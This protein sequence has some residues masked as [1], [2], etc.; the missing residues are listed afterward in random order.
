[1][2]CTFCGK[3]LQPWMSACP[4]CG[5]A[6]SDM[7][8]TPF[9]SAPSSTAAPIN[10]MFPD[11][12]ASSQ[13][14]PFDSPSFGPDAKKHSTDYGI[15]AI[16]PATSPT[17]QPSYTPPPM[18]AYTTPYTAQPGQAPAAPPQMA[19]G[20][21]T[22]RLLLLYV[23][24]A[25]IALASGLGLILYSAVIHP[26]QL[27][28]QATATALAQANAAAS[29]TAQANAAASATAQANANAT[30]TAAAQATADAQATATALQNIY[31][32]ATSGA[33]ALNDS[34]AYNA[35]GWDVGLAQGGGGCSFYGGAYHVAL[36]AKGYYFPCTANA[37]NFGNFAFQ[38][39]VTLDKGDEAGILFRGNSGSAQGYLFSIR[40][41]GSYDLFMS[42]NNNTNKDLAYGFSPV[43]KTGLNQTNVLTVVA[44]A[45]NMYL[46]INKQFAASASDLTYA[47]GQIGVFVADNATPTDAYFTNAQVW[48]L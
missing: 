6:T 14:D 18:Q 31:L 21:E 27:H 37:T 41:D 19:R 11:S 43:I 28:Q 36:D 2:H 38:I 17:P 22:N 42:K 13:P 16:I 46:Y 10:T 12:T 9:S 30:A 34:M 44:R 3:P 39:N 4:N 32:S 40:R 5:T 35:R 15:P 1:M 29:A 24:L 47:S 45:G 26:A 33:P 20:R 7:P 23:A 25:L 8:P 48:K